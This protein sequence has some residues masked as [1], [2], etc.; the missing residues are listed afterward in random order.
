MAYKNFKVETDSDGIALVTWDIP[1]RSMNVLDE[2]STSELDA[3]VKETTA[4]AAVKGVV[5]TSA[6]EAFCAGADLSMLEGMNQ[7]YAKLFKEQGE[8]AANQML[9]DQS[10]R[11]SLVLR[12]IETSGKPWAAAI[13]GLA[14]GGGFEITLC[15]HYRVAAENPKTRL[16]LPEVKVGLFPGAGGTQRVPRLVP[17]QDAM[18]ILLKGDPVTVEKAKALNLIHAIVPAADLVKAAKDW[19]KGGG[20]AVA[21]WDEKGFKLP[22][23]PVFSKAG[24]MMFPAG[25]AI[26]RRET[27]DNYPA[28][29]A[30]M[31]CVYEGLQPADRRRA[32]GGV[33][34]LHL[35][36]ALEGSGR[37]D[38]QP[39]PVDA[40]IEQG[41]AP[42]EGCAADQ[43]E[44]DR[45]DRR[46]VHGRERRLC[47]GP[48]RPRC[49]SDRSRPGERRQGQGACAKGDR[50]ADQEGTRQA[51]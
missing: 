44:E 9:F 41:R 24:M 13:N 49:R 12:S 35:G 6:K 23:G 51:F 8:T 28:A 10:R 40:G 43:G 39:V 50:G 33:T 19:I 36:A 16:G 14:L 11:F 17:P 26:Y 20:K 29:R 4:D 22:A 5:I 25:N 32:A 18:T 37:D 21:P 30:I 1:G 7:A 46:R 15:C 42:S 2:T 34:L 38:P 45:R 47:L 27:Y 48:C 31:S 3:I